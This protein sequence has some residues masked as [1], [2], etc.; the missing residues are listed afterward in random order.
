MS[1]TVRV[2]WAWLG[3]NME[4]WN[5]VQARAVERYGLPGDRYHCQVGVEHM[6]YIFKDRNDALLFAMEHSGSVIS[7]QQITVEFI[8]NLL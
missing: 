7:D 3:P 4:M 5:H 1:T 2:P 8:S 6:D